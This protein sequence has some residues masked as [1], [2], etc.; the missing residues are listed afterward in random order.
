V[1]AQHVAP[2]DEAGSTNTIFGASVATA[3]N[4]VA[5]ITRD[6]AM[7]A[8]IAST[9]SACRK[10][11]PKRR[12]SRESWLMPKN[13]SLYFRGTSSHRISGLI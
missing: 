13:T 7:C 6:V 10:W 8:A 4:V 11:K 9:I 2:I 1:C 12:G 5:D 3:E